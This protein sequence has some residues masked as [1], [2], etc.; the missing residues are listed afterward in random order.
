MGH[1]EGE[2]GLCF[3]GEN[4]RKELLSNTST[5]D[6]FKLASSSVKFVFLNACY[7]E[8]QAKIIVQH[9]PQ[10]IG[11][12]D[13]IPDTTALAFAEK[14]YHYVG[15]NKP[16]TEAFQWAKTLSKAHELADHLVPVLLS[17]SDVE[18]ADQVRQAEAAN[19]AGFST[20]PPKPDIFTPSSPLLL[21]PTSSEYK[22][23]ADKHYR[24]IESELD[25]RWGLLNARRVS[26]LGNLQR[27]LGMDAPDVV[28]IYTS[29]ENG[30][31]YLDADRH[32][33]TLSLD[34]LVEWFQQAGLRPLLILV[35]H[36]RFNVSM[37]PDNLQKQTRLIWC[38][39]TPMPSA[40]DDLSNTVRLFFERSN[41]TNSGDLQTLIS[42]LDHRKTVVSECITPASPLEIKVD[43][44]TQRK[45]QQFRAA[46][47]RIMLG[48]ETV[49]STLGLAIQQH[50]GN[51]GVFVYAVAGSELSCVFDL[52]QQI[53]Y[54]MLPNQRNHQG[55]LIVNWPLH[56]R[57][58]ADT[59]EDD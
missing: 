31:L 12:S 37:V 50:L 27:E 13:K 22:L 53:Y 39:Y 4:G 19:V 58:E 45:S 59:C 44:Q 18:S 17:G 6:I 46:M 35:L 41:Q 28:Y 7:S 14:F 16:V 56:I 11:M 49:K 25:S 54:K 55:V 29:F 23:V 30:Q 10:V 32:G 1:G 51:S 2:A 42:Q 40:L 3:E 9:I 8:I 15:L 34:Q 47:L 38:L 52:P 57:I 33:N 24:E 36:G 43:A 21:I 20:Q 48:R 5:D 26:T